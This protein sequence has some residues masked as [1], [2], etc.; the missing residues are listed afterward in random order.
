M[1]SAIIYTTLPESPFDARQVASRLLVEVHKLEQ[2]EAVIQLGEYVWQVNFLESPAAFATL[3]GALEQ[4]RLPYGIL[5]L[6]DAPQWILGHPN[7][8]RA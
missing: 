6:A 8:A 7:R 1:H 2:N 5:Q 4:L 3:V